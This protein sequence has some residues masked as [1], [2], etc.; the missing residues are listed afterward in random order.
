MSNFA[1]AI[2]VRYKN[3]FSA[4]NTRAMPKNMYHRIKYFIIYTP[5]KYQV[6]FQAKTWYLHM[7]KH[8]CCY[9]YIINRTFHTKQ[10]FK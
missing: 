7:W 8:H 5:M 6:S 1:G 2:Q 3:I 4:L 10:L 9:G